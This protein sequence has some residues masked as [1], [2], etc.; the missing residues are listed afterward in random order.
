[1][2]ILGIIASAITGNLVTTSYESIATV[3]VGSG[4]A[5][6]VEFTS[7]PATYTHLQVRGIGRSL[8]ANT[9]VDVQYLR[10]NSDTGSNY[11]WHQ[12]VGN[13]SSA[14]AAAGTSTSFMRGGYIALD[15]EPAN[16]FG[17]V[18]I[19]ILDYKNTNKYKT[20]RIL[21]GTEYNNSNGGVSFNSGLW[22]NTDAITTITLQPSGANFAEYSQFALYGIKGS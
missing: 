6:N 7:I 22:Q 12:L 20:V 18:V 3:T 19:D 4:G 1:M 5:A 13:G 8:E 15:S 21:S 9:G 2:P 16:V 10:F 17:G 14:D 11:A